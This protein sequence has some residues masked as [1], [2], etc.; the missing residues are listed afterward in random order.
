[1]LS[2]DK[3]AEVGNDKEQVWNS[4][5]NTLSNSKTKVKPLFY[6]WMAAA[7]IVVICALLGLYMF[8]NSNNKTNTQA[9]AINKNNSVK[10]IE[11][12]SNK[13]ILQLAD[14]STIIL[15]SMNNG[16]KQKL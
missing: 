11:P 3:T 8:N 1:M 4:I 15:D 16:N 14:G 9:L 12:G 7:S 5:S 6:R 13:A 10:D 2:A